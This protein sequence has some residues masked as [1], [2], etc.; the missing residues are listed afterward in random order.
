[1]KKLLISIAFIIASAAIH[2]TDPFTCDDYS[3]VDIP[4]AG[5]T[6]AAT[7]DP[8]NHCHYTLVATPAAGYK[9]AYW[10]DIYGSKSFEPTIELAINTAHQNALFQATFVR[11]NAYIH[12]WLADELIYRSTSTDVLSDAAADGFV[13]TYIDGELFEDEDNAITRQDYGLW[14]K[15]T[16]AFGDENAYAGKPI[17]LIL[18]NSCGVPSAVIDT[19]VP[20][21]VSSTIDASSLDFHSDVEHTDVQVYDDAVL[22]I[23][24]DTEINGYLDIHAGGKVVVPEG[25]TL[26]VNGI[27]MRGNGLTK[28]WAQLVVEG[29]IINNNNDTIFYDYTLDQHAY[30]P[31]SLP[32]DVKCS[33]IYNPIN[34]QASSYQ[35]YIFNSTKRENKSY[36]WENFDDTQEGAY[37][38]AG[39]GY[40]VYAVPTRWQNLKDKRQQEAIMRF[41]MVVD[42]TTG[43]QDERIIDTY[44]NDAEGL[45][46]WDRN[47]NLIGNPYM[48]NIVMGHTTPA[49]VQALQGTLDEHD[50]FVP[51]E[52]GT[53]S[54][55]YITYTED[56][57]RSYK[58]EQLSNFIMLPFNSYLTQTPNGD[59]LLFAKIPEE[60]PAPHRASA[61]NNYAME[62]LETGIILSQGES[63]DHLG[64]LFGNFTDNYE[65]NADLTKEF[66]EAQPLST[67]SLMGTTPMAY[68]ALSMDAITRPIPLGYRKAE[69]EQMTF[70][71]DKSRYNPNQL[72]GLWLTDIVTG[73]TVNLLVE[74]YTFTPE[75]EQDD[76][77]F[78]LSC[79]RRKVV[80]VTTNVDE[81]TQQRTIIRV[82]DMFGREMHG[83]VN[84][85]PQG[86]YILMDDL[87]NTSK[88]I[89]GQ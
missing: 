38:I 25:N 79:E 32:Y 39:K 49:K 16:S 80:D 53:R 70:S 21:M 10:T 63:S 29:A 48:S 81:A 78:Y 15:A 73:E 23:D 56:G 51:A 17:H 76:S 68:L 66:G 52:Y 12:E 86:V 82:F 3:K 9:L 46:D 13:D 64:L 7:Q 62:E 41:P 55:R 22:T 87:G 14:S 61:A 18:H 33:E 11:A 42:L 74:D 36:A 40:I 20:V 60:A 1:M 58:Q 57:F 71:F 75:S 34:K 8:D 35:S 72:E 47:W 65:L 26:T 31:L 54:L 5:G 67:Y 24:D 43:N 59:K 4:S 50:N 19:I 85:L 6:I 89:L 88:E 77:R 84:A 45:D 83:D 44:T 27:I 69:S 30:Y 37:F 2:A 28:K